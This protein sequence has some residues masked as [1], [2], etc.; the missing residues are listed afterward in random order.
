MP[1]TL[2]RGS[3][4][5]HCLIQT[6][7]HI[8]SVPKEELCAR[9]GI[10]GII[11]IHTKDYGEFPSGTRFTHFNLQ[12]S[13]HVPGDIYALPKIVTPGFFISPDNEQLPVLDFSRCLIARCVATKEHVPYDRLT[14]EDF[15]HSFRHIQDIET[16]KKEILWRYTQSLPSLP[17]A[18][19]LA[20]GVGITELEI[21]KQLD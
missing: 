1:T 12:A 2:P 3:A 14:E 7:G 8:E 4:A 18:D 5:T 13:G 21:T 11:R 9:Y 6:D 16:L 15:A 20:L 17:P 19:M 10:D